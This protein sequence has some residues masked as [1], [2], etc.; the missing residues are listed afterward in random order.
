MSLT[1]IDS[2]RI[3]ELSGHDT[4]RSMLEARHLN[5][6]AQCR[7][8]LQM[9]QAA[10]RLGVAQMAGFDSRRVADGV[11]HRLATTPVAGPMR[12]ARRVG[13]WLAGLAAAAA[14]VFAVGI[15]TRNRPAGGIVP[16]HLAALST[17]HELD[18][19]GAPELEEVLRSIPPA[20]E[21]LGHVEIA[22]FNELNARDLE[23]VLR[24]MEER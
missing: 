2:D 3:V 16:V 4:E 19:L 18:G 6:C 24:S 14:V 21:A 5:E 7:L 22:S 11:R 1:H 9:T 17:L 20:S 12:G 15:G 13:Y 23:L 8:E 10:R